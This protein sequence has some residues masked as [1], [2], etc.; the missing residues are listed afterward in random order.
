MNR[1]KP[2]GGM[3]W[4][5]ML[6]TMCAVAAGETDKVLQFKSAARTGQH[7]VLLGTLPHGRVVRLL[8]ANTDP[9][10]P[11]DPVG[12]QNQLIASLKAGDLVQA[13]WDTA[14]GVNT[15]S[16][17]APYTP[18]PGELTPNGYV[19]VHSEPKS[20]KS[21][22]LVVTLD[23]LGEVTKWAVPAAKDDNGETARD[24]GIDQTLGNLHEGDSVWADISPGSS[25]TLVALLAYAELVSGKLVKTEVLDVS[26]HKQP[27][28]QIDQNGTV[29]EAE[30]PG[31]MKNGKWAVDLRIMSEVRRCKVGEAVLFRVQ[32]VEADNWLREIVPVPPAPVA[33][34]QGGQGPQG[35]PDSGSNTDANGV[36]KGRTIGGGT[37]GVGGIGIGGF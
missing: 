35:T 33:S 7:L 8:V 4:G 14:D 17:I 27:A 32:L 22:D 10:G 9:K 21:P 29:M 25:P 13:S 6:L 3:A 1:T 16:A 34:G 15:I 23:K 11:F 18:K 12:D 5:M 37:P 24:P 28:V 19:Y 2:I 20:E 36:P 30:V 26:G 31:S